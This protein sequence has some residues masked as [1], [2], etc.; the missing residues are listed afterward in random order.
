[1]SKKIAK[2]GASLAALAAIAVGSSA[3]A[4]AATDKKNATPPAPAP[5]QGYPYPPPGPPPP[6]FRGF[7][8]H[9]P[10]TPLTGE[11]AQKVK[12]AALAKVK[13]GTVMRLEA[14]GPQGSKYEAHVRKADGTPVLVL[15]DKDFKV[16]DVRTFRGFPGGPR[17]GRGFPGHGPET[18]LTGDTAQKVKDAALAKVKGGTVE[19]VE[20]D[21]EKGSPYEAHVRKPDGTEAIVRVNKQFEVTSVDAFD[22]RRGGPY[23]GPPPGFPGVPPTGAP[24]KGAPRRG[25]LPAPPPPGAPQA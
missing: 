7:H 9:H 23:G 2:V 24:P 10:G 19:R 5:G 8:G 13:G 4:G 3:I 11:T 25:E 17:D 20:A 1:M 12:Y 21:G 22:G 15:V 6:G 16:T 18:P 14:D